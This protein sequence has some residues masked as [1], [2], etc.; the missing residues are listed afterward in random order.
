MVSSIF[1]KLSLLLARL[2]YMSEQLT[3]FN[4]ALSASQLTPRHLAHWN[5]GTEII[6]SLSNMKD[7]ALAAIREDDPFIVI[8]LRSI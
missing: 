4:K 7:T 5:A 2:G 6:G 1:C 3:A 8:V